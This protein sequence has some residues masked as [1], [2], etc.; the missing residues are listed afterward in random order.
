MVNLSAHYQKTNAQATVFSHAIIVYDCG[1]FT[2]LF[3]AITFEVVM[4]KVSS[5]NRAEAQMQAWETFTSCR[6]NRIYYH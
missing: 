3:Q 1:I 6:G 4:Q 2:S 5:A